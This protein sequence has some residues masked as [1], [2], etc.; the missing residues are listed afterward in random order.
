VTG[1]DL[2]RAM[3]AEAQQLS[4]ARGVSLHA[5][6]GLAERLPFASGSFDAIACR[7]CAHHFMDVE[8]SIREMRRV[9]RP[10]GV[11]MFN[12]HV[13]PEDDAADAFVNRLDWLRDPSHRREPR[14]SEYQAWFA[15]VGLIVDHV[16]QRR[17][18]I[19]ADQWFARART[20]PEHEAEARAM[21]SAAPASLRDLF[22]VSDDPLAF[23]L[24]AVIVRA[25]AEA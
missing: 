9:L 5:V 4:Q 8:E 16:E 3:L 18:R 7:F 17:L 25:T 15:N 21:L 1:L 6:Q 19:E 23:D 22:N 20:S 10:G 24:H 2:T 12:D 13:A 14:L 11:L